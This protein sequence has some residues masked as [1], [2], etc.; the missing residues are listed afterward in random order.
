[1]GRRPKP[2]TEPIA[3]PP[4]TSVGWWARRWTRLAATAVANPT[5]AAVPA[6]ESPEDEGGAEGGEGV[7]AREAAAGGR[8]HAGLEVVL[9]PLALDGRLHHP[10][11]E[12]RGEAGRGERHDRP[13]PVRAAPPCLQGGQH[14]PD[15]PVVGQVGDDGGGPV[16]L[17]A[18]PEGLEGGVDR[19]VEGAH[20]GP[21]TRRRR[22][23][24]P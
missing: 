15:E 21:L 24:R 3:A 16:D 4:I 14:H 18:A 7:A 2:R 22:G 9:G 11:H 6:S 23:R 17:G 19:L 10:A 12:E 1:M 13:P 5:L 8:A 20:R